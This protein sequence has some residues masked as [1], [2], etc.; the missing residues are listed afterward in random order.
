[1]ITLGVDSGLIVTAETFYCGC[2]IEYEVL[3]RENNYNMVEA[4]RIT[5]NIKYCPIHAIGP[6]V[7]DAM[8]GQDVSRD[9]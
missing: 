1:M 5:G 9:R 4:V 3:H 6:K 2:V 7:R 8:W